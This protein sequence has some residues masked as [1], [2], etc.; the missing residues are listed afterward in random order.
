MGQPQLRG[1]GLR[2][3][4]AAPRKAGR[5]DRTLPHGAVLTVAETVRIILSVASC[6]SGKFGKSAIGRD[7]QGQDECHRPSLADAQSFSAVRA[8]NRAKVRTA[9]ANGYDRNLGSILR[10]PE[11]LKLD[12]ENASR[13]RVKLL[14]LSHGTVF[15]DLSRKCSLPVTLPAKS[16][17]VCRRGRFVRLRITK[18]NPDIIDL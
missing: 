8:T 1:S 14:M 5:G 6:R 16:S 11:I 18:E 13:A 15:A 12:D 10:A 4:G 2:L 17:R 3:P 9:G 7:W